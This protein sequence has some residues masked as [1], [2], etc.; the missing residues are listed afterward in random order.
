MA[1]AAALDR[2]AKYAYINGQISIYPGQT[3]YDR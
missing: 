3:A 2:A 1:D